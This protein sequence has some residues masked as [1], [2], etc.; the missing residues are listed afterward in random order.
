MQD[1]IPTSENMMLKALCSSETVGLASSPEEALRFLS[2]LAWFFH[3][4]AILSPFSGACIRGRQ[5]SGNIHTWCPS[6][7]NGHPILKTYKFDM[8]QKQLEVA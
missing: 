2:L 4:F 6:K 3:F 5:Q 1:G 7:I 8:Q